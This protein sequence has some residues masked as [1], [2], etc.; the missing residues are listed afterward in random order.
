[1]FKT[2]TTLAALISVVYGAAYTLMPGFVNSLYMEANPQSILTG[3][4]FG[5]SLLFIGLACWFLRDAR[6]ASTQRGLSI[7]GL[8]NAVVGFATSL[9]FTLNGGLSAMGWSATVIYL[10][11]GVMWLMC[12]RGPSLATAEA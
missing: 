6:E 8:V 4:Y 9:V 2:T 12:L 10:V 1:M 7:A 5:L 3:R 11:L